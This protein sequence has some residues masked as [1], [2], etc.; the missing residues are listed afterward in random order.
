MLTDKEIKSMV[1]SALKQRQP[2]SILMVVPDYT[3]CFSNAGLIANTAY[4]W[5]VEN[6]VK[7]ELLEA[8]GTH[9]PMT[10]KEIAA[11][12]GDIPLEK[13]HGHDWRNDVVKIGQKIKIP[14]RGTGITDKPKTVKAGTTDVKIDGEFTEDGYLKYKPEEFDTFDGDG[15]GIIQPYQDNPADDIATGEAIYLNLIY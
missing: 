3:R 8:L 4:H 11:M 2:K 12:Y 1:V 13:F 10:E 14:A 6:N 5:C 7:V 9:V 15:V